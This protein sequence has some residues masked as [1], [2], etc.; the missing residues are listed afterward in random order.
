M[1]RQLKDGHQQSRGK[2]ERVS[3]EKQLAILALSISCYPY[4]D[5]SRISVRV[6][7]VQF[8]VI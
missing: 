4:E 3:F 2:N 8:I 6:K 5:S 1:P 7:Y